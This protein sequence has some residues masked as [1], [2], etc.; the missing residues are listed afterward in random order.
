VFQA[1]LARPP[2]SRPAFL[3]EACDGDAELRRELEGLLAAHEDAGGFLSTPAG[4][5]PTSAAGAVP[6]P[7]PGA[8]PQRIAAYK[9]L[10]TIAHGGMGTVYR[11]VR[12]DDAFRKT[13][14][15]KLVRA[16]HSGSFERRFRQERQILAGLQH[17][18]IATVLDGGT[19][20]D[21]QP[22]LVMEYVDG[23]PITDFCA[24]RATGL[25]DRLAL[26]RTVCGAVDY[27]H[28]NLVVHRDIKPANVLVDGQGVV[29]LLDFG[30][31]KLLAAGDDPDA[32]PTA[33]VLPIMTPEYASPEQVKGQLVT[34][35]SDVYSLG[36]LLYELLAGRR[37]Y[38]VQADSLE[39]IVR[40]VCHTEARPPSEAVAGRPG[41][42]G[43]LASELRGDVDTIVLKALRKEP[44]RRYRTAHELSA[45]IR[46][47]LEGHPVTARVDTIRYRAGKF[48]RRHRTAVAAA[49]LVSATLVGGIV[50]TT[51]QAR[52]AERRFD[53]ARRLIR[54]IIFDI[55]PKLGTVPGTTALRKGLIE[56]TLQYLEAMARDAGDNPAL[57]RELASSYVQLA[58]VQGIQGDANVGDTEAARRTLGEA[59][60]LVERLL[61]LDPDGADSLHEAAVVERHVALSF[62]Y[63][64]A[65]PTAQQHARRA[66]ELAERQVGIRPDFQARQ[67]LAD[68]NRTLGN[69][70]D[71][72][73]AF[74]RSRDLYEDLLLEKPGEPEVS[75][76]LSQVHKY[77]AGLHYRKDEYRAGLEL[78]AKARAIDEKLLAANPENPQ[79]QAD[80]TFA[81][82][83]L[84]WGHAN[85]GELRP[86]IA[87]M[88]ETLAMRERIVARNPENTRSQ[89]QLAYAFRAR[90]R[91]WRQTG[92]RAAARQDYERAHAIYTDLRARGYGG[93]YAGSELGVT[94]LALG[95]V[96]EE[97]GRQAEACQWYRRSAEVYGELAARGAVLPN[98]KEDAETARRAAEACGRRVSSP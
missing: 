28:H 1:A 83:Q 90:A 60:K 15:L 42:A 14:A 71:S 44:E 57:L 84:S 21:G 16:G 7:G 72:A 79:A 85:L 38:E 12:D 63:Q 77:V 6:A 46:R 61:K 39:A 78:I 81:L 43:P 92:D 37:P 53:E 31:A 47:H 98:H 20:D 68:A 4:L 59:E 76:N 45:D 64:G 41:A 10:D 75:R 18:H 52:L 3:D 32:A 29:K 50:T 40:S 56:S 33:T 94:E 93:A 36:V 34:T 2:E 11:A 73:E 35:A 17:P 91:L 19:T 86:A 97:E 49:V 48:V 22:F 27:A 74:A 96:A 80:L 58:R 30:I 26:F 87:A 5:P 89:D 95:Q 69:A 8:A 82:S 66:I 65:F 13:V 62:L 55:Q 25:R 51:R 24:A 23:Q 88:Q 54:T 9:I 70:S 67:D